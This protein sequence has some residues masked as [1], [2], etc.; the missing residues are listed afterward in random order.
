MANDKQQTE[1]VMIVNIYLFNIQAIVVKAHSKVFV[2]E[3]FV[4]IRQS[5]NKV[6][7]INHPEVL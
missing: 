1:K 7:A 6:I 3:C 5:R 2:Q 4:I